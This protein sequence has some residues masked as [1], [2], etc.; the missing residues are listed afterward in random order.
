MMSRVKK[1]IIAGFAATVAVSVLEVANLFLNH[2]FDPFPGVVARLFGM[3]GNMAAGWGLHLVIGT[4]ALGSL[5]G[6]LYP[7]L[8]SATPVT[9]GIVFAVGAW[10]LMML[11][12]TMAGD[13]R[14]FTGSS[15]FGTFGWMLAL[16]M[17][18]GAVMGNVY[19]RLVERERRGVAPIGAAPAH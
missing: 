13:Y 6:V 19:A 9:K 16:H 7:R 17:V 3:P 11:Y 2:L 1:G 12:I 15:G 14:T 10:V 18:F 4:F 8:P 5:F